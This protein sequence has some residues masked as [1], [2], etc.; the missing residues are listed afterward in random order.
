[1][2]IVGIEP[3]DLC[4]IDMRVVISNKICHLMRGR[5]FVP[6]RAHPWTRD[7]SEAMNPSLA[8]ANRTESDVHLLATSKPTGDQ[9]AM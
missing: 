1:M 4:I 2:Q 8:L 6:W 5:C 7:R 3:D 9:D